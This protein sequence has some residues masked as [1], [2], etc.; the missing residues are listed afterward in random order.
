MKVHRVVSFTP[1]AF[2][3]PYIS[4]NSQKR[5]AARNEF[6]KDFY[7]LKN[8]SLFGKTMENVRRRIDFRLCN[9]PEKFQTYTS[10]PLFLSATRFTEDL[11]GVELLKGKVELD[12]PV[13]ISQA[14]LDLSKLIMYQLRY[15]KLVS[16]ETRFGGSLCVI[17][18]DTDS[19]FLEVQDMSVDKQ[20]LP[21]MKEH[22]LLDSSNYPRE[23]FLYSSDNRAKLGCIKDECASVPIQDAIFLRPV[24]ARNIDGP[25][26]SK[27]RY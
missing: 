19:F 9:T 25:R 21:A 7:K 1:A 5:Q 17:A 15:E 27:G 2:F 18:G 20:L 6:E 22:G 16:Y 14:V 26:A 8:N 4:F 23:H 12:K 10:R 11:V 13:F 3:Q 24:M